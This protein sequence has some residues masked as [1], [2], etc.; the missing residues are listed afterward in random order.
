[1]SPVLEADAVWLVPC[2][3]EPGGCKTVS[4]VL[5]AADPAITLPATVVTNPGPMSIGVTSGG[6][7][8]AEL[9]LEPS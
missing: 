6:C 8:L 7:E 2:D 1:M 4:P 9:L 5:L 3:A